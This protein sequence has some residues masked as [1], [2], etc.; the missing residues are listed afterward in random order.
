MPP[1][2]KT[3]RHKN[4]LRNLTQ[5]PG[6]LLTPLKPEPCP[7]TKGPDHK[8]QP[9]ARHLLTPNCARPQLCS[10]ANHTQVQQMPSTPSQTT[11]KAITLTTPSM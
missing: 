11:T 2:P 9:T 8:P 3:T 10:I 7:Y 6:L 4:T 5:P 1:A